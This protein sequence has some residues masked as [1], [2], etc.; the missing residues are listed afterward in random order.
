MLSRLRPTRRPAPAAAMFALLCGTVLASVAADPSA[1]AAPSA[2][3]GAGAADPAGFSVA[4]GP[5]GPLDLTP[6]RPVSVTFTVVDTSTGAE[7]IAVSLTGLRFEGDSPQFSGQPSP[8]LTATAAPAKVTLAPGASADIRVSLTAAASAPPGG[9][10]AGVVFTDEVPQRPGQVSVQAAQARPLIGHVAG[11][12]TDSGRIAG[13]VGSRPAAGGLRFAVPFLDTGTIDYQVRG[14][15]TVTAGSSVVGQVVISSSLVLPGN[16]RTLTA[17]YTGAA[18]AGPLHAHLHLVWGVSGE[19]SGDAATDVAPVV[20]SAVTGATTPGAAAL[21]PTIVERP[22][23]AH[24]RAAVA[25][26]PG[27]RSGWDWLLYGLDLLV[28]LLA[29]LLLV[30]LLRSRERRRGSGSRRDARPAGQAS[31]GP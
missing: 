21:A 1:A 2:A 5:S 15:V 10:Y 19:H 24:H 11:A 18:P 7:H 8:G 17:I 25:A 3:A 23:P 20:P 13:F 6:G 12:V 30:A 9:L 27:R 26:R 16:T 31:S 28:L 14:T 29:V 4:G 22:A